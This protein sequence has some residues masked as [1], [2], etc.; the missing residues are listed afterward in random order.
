[1]L[2]ASRQ[3]WAY[4]PLSKSTFCTFAF[5]GLCV[6]EVAAVFIERV[7]VKSRIVPVSFVMYVRLSAC[8]TAAHTG[9]ISV[10]FSIT[11]YHENLSN[12]LKFN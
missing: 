4:G 3:K 5:L 11:D 9:R 8:I 7:R 6:S 10:K 1:M 2:E 12:Q